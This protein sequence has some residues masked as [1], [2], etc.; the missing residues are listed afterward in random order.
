[1]SRAVATLKK[2]TGKAHVAV[3]YDSNVD[4]FSSDG[5]FRK[6]K[7]KRDVALIATTREGDVFGCFYNVAMSRKAKG[8]WDT[9]IFA[10]SFESRGRCMTP[11]RFMLL[12][13]AK[14]DASVFAHPKSDENHWF[15]EVGA[16]EHGCIGFGNEKSDLWCESLSGVFE[17]MQD[18]TLTGKVEQD[19]HTCVRLIAVSFF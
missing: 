15:V 18:T 3:L 11:Q 8:F 4:E 13:D 14:F 12:D 10:F 17:G 7:N 19:Y 5:M 6:I 9:N 2:W 16:L 1:M